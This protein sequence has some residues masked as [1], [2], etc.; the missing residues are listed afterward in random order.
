MIGWP[1]IGKGY[2]LR[3]INSN[4]IQV[5]SYGDIM[6][7]YE[8]KDKEIELLR[9]IAIHGEQNTKINRDE[10]F[11]KLEIIFINRLLPIILSDKPIVIFDNFPVHYK[12]LNEFNIKYKLYLIIRLETNNFERLKLN[13][14]NRD[15]CDSN[16]EKKIEKRLSTYKNIVIPNLEMMSQVPLRILNIDGLDYHKIINSWLSSFYRIFDYLYDVKGQIKIIDK[17]GYLC[18]LWCDNANFSNYPLSYINTI[19]G[20]IIKKLN[21]S[22]DHYRILESSNLKFYLICNPKYNLNLKDK[23]N[24]IRFVCWPIFINCSS[25]PESIHIKTEEQSNYKREGFI[26]RFNDTWYTLTI[27]RMEKSY[28]NNYG[29]IHRSYK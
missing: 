4:Y 22:K 11:R 5:I 23:V 9:N 21:L 25:N 12:A 19:S 17:N 3:N 28:K 13:M 27:I 6:R 16:T 7:E 29:F 14:F 26:I 1:G 18:K 24:P 8:A 10:A 2:L 20:N 15:R